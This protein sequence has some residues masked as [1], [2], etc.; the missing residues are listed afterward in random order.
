MTVVRSHG[1]GDMFVVDADG[2]T[3][4]VCY[5]SEAAMAEEARALSLGGDTFPR[6]VSQGKTPEL[7]DFISLTLDTAG[8]LPVVEVDLAWAGAMGLVRAVLDAA[9]Q[10][11]A[12]GF[13]WE[14]LATDYYVKEGGR[15]VVVRARGARRRRAGEA[16]NAKPALEALA[17]ALLPSPLARGTPALVRLLLP[18][19]N[20]TT[21][22]MHTVEEARKVV[23][24]ADALV[25]PSEGE[26]S[27]ELSDPGLR[28]PHNEDATAVVDGAARG[29]RF[30]VLVVCDGVSSATHSERASRIAS[31]VTRDRI[32]AFM[33]TGDPGRAEDA[34][35]DAI[36]A[37]H[38]AICTAGIDHGDGAPPGT[39]IVA[40]LVHHQKLTIGWVGDSRAYWVSETGS[41][42]CTT[43]HSW[44]NDA[45]SSGEV[46]LAEALTS[47]YAHA[48]TRCLGPLEV[49]DGPG[50]SV[51]ADVRE[52]VLTGPGHLVLCTD[53]LWNY[54][55][56][57]SDIEALVN[58]AGPGASP[59][60]IARF[61]VCRALTEGG[62]D[63]VSVAVHAVS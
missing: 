55:P 58:A 30:T 42:L 40:A 19:Q 21:V 32:A 36:V 44:L 13:T 62:G 2:E 39:T 23:D 43:D 45:V 6:V 63:N 41:E 34:V 59:S 38:V 50:F 7:G 22:A 26:R 17:E 16:F 10:I 8:A 1:I 5:G 14:P 11:A 20:Y 4:L 3:R 56:L 48:L 25:L 51:H 46:S 18:R 27:S 54:F 9:E 53:G 35:R 60:A 12:R 24:H 37:A 29:E 28:R 15:L 61:L 47:P 52:R 33:E 49:N 31:D 57:A